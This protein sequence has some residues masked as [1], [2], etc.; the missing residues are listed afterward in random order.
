MRQR[1]RGFLFGEYTIAQGSAIF[2]G[3]FLISA[4][5]GVVR[6][7]LF[8]A[9]FGA[10]AEA[11]AYYAAF[12][13]PDT[14]ANLISGGALSNAMI[15]VLLRAAHAGGDQAEEH[16]ANL[17]L[18]LLT[19]VVALFVA[20]SWLAAPWFV[21]VVLAPGFDAPTAALAVT[22]TR[23][24]LLQVLLAVTSSVAIAL[25]N[26]RNQFVLTGLVIA[27]TNITIVAGILAAHYIP[28]V[29]IYGPTLGVVA[30]ALIQIAIL[31]PGVAANRLRLRPAWDLADRRLRQVIRVLIPNG[32]SAMVDYAGGIVDTAFATLAREAAGL[33][34]LHNALLLIGLPLRLLGI[35]LAQAAFPRLAAHAANGAWQHMHATLR[36]ALLAAVGMAVPTLLGLLLAG[37]ELIRVLFERGRFDADAGGLTYAMLAIYALGLPAYVATEVLTR[38]LIALHDTITPLLTNLLQTFWRVV[39]IWLLLEPAGV[40]A[41]PIAFAVTSACETLLLGMVLFRRLRRLQSLPAAG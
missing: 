4:A 9:Q 11:S 40:A 22:L 37:R 1:L 39:L 17:V 41:I 33:P 32:L 7:V 23:M 18:T 31:L 30:D 20:I 34:A 15:P 14:I 13:M 21:R 2:I 24:L 26:R 10:G 8:N 3:A 29:G 5:L 38:A 25:L 19:L 28:G 35:A 27:S 36:R 6:Q 12:R 16:L